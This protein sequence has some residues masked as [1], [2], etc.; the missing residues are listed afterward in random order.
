MKFYRSLN[1]THRLSFDLIQPAGS[2]FRWITLS[3][4]HK[5][6]SIVDTQTKKP[7]RMGGTRARSCHCQFDA[8][9]PSLMKH[10]AA[11]L[12][13]WNWNDI[14]FR[15]RKHRQSEGRQC[16]PS[17]FSAAATREFL[18]WISFGLH[19]L[20]MLLVKMIKSTQFSQMVLRLHVFTVFY[21]TMLCRREYFS[22][23]FCDSNGF[24]CR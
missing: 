22:F 21:N 6:M 19:V 1:G 9:F 2:L 10:I 24:F 3:W 8:F 11:P 20:Q 12:A 14:F 7:R 16:Q 5:H 23:H 13:W 4:L 18:W 15:R 17:S